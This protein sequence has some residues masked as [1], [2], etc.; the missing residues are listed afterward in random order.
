MFLDERQIAQPNRRPVVENRF[1][2]G[3]IRL[4]AGDAVSA[5]ADFQQEFACPAEVLRL[6]GT[7]AIPSCR[8]SE[9][10]TCLPRTLTANTTLPLPP[11]VW[12]FESTPTT[13]VN[14]LPGPGKRTITLLTAWQ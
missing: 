11:D 9:W 13:A 3:P 8:I 14:V 1:R 10:N 5:I 7:A 2:V 6:T 12:L 4:V